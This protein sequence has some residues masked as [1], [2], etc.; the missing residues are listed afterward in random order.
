MNLRLKYY[1]FIVF[2]CLTLDLK[3]QVLK[4]G[5]KITLDRIEEKEQ[6]KR[7]QE[8][9]EQEV[10][11]HLDT[12]Q[13]TDRVYQH[14][15]QE[16]QRKYTRFEFG[17]GLTFP[18]LL[19]DGIQD[20]EDN[21][22]L[23]ELNYYVTNRERYG[24]SFVH[25]YYKQDVEVSAEYRLLSST[26][27]HRFNLYYDH[28]VSD[29]VFMFHKNLEV[30]V[31]AGISL[32]HIE[33]GYFVMLLDGPKQIVS[34]VKIRDRI[35]LNL[36]LQA[37]QYLARNLKFFCRFEYV[38][39]PPFWVEDVTA[40]TISGEEVGFPGHYAQLSN[41]SLSLGLGIRM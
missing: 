3:S 9:V 33:A 37:N 22:M 41:A 16:Y 2:S 7:E 19:R 39:S 20:L 17:V 35:G 40:I 11:Q 21:P 34:T 1:I 14:Q 5:L 32:T 26:K 13:T 30:L 12:F 4:E 28:L 27:R 38:V 15:A 25:S 6:S 36:R 29:N 18:E 31:G 10:E 23:L 8:E 24:F